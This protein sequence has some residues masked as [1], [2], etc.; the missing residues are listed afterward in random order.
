MYKRGENT[1]APSPALAQVAPAVQAA[2]ERLADSLRPDADEPT[3]GRRRVV[4][5]RPVEAA[6]TS[7]LAAPTIGVARGRLVGDP[8][9][10]REFRRTDTIVIR[11]RLRGGAAAGKADEGTP[12]V[13]GRLLDRRGQP[14]TDLPLTPGTDEPEVRLALG[15]LGAGDYVVEL[16][17]RSGDETVQQYVAFR[18]VR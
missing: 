12:A 18:V 9:G 5:P 17:A 13:S 15:N 10:R 6:A 16:I 11:A 4:M 14:L 3:D 8:V 2:V 7:L 1:S